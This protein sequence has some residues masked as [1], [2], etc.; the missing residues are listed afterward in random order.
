MMT[1]L[2]PSPRIAATGGTA[3]SRWRA[4]LT[5]PVAA[6]VVLVAFWF[7]LLASLD[8]KSLTSDEIVHATAGYT[9]WAFD[10]YRLNPENG[11]L[12][13]RVAGLALLTGDYQ[14]PPRDTDAWR[15]SNE[16]ELGDIWFHQMGHRVEDMLRRGRGA[17][18]LLSVI[19][20]ALVWAT[21]RRLFGPEGGML[22]L[23]V[24]VTSPIVLANGAL[25][26]SDAAC[27]LFFLAAT[28]ALWATLQR[29]TIPR[30]LGSGLLMGGLFVAKMSAVLVIPMA[31]LL[32]L[33]RALSGRA[34][35][36]LIGG[37]RELADLR[38][39]VA[40]LAAVGAVHAGLTVLVIWAFYGFRFQTFAP[41]AGAFERFQHPWRY[42]LERPDPLALLQEVNLTEPQKAR[43][44]AILSGFDWQHQAEE[45]AR[46]VAAQVLTPGQRAQLERRLA[47][48]PTRFAAQAFDFVRQHRL[49]PEAYV[50]G[51]AHAWRFAR[52]R[53]AFFNGEYGITGWKTFFPYTFA[54]KTP[55]ALFAILALAAAAVVVRWRRRAREEGTS[56]SQSLADG[57]YATLPLWVLLLVYWAAVIPGRL[58]IGHRHIMATY[59][60]LLV[61]AGAAGWWLKS[62]VHAPGMSRRAGRWISAA[63]VALLAALVAEMAYRFPHYISYFNG[64]VTPDKAYR[65]LVDSSLDWGQDLPGVRRYLAERQ[66]R[67]PVYFSY[68]GTASPRY[69]G[70]EA[71]FLYSPTVLDGPRTPVREL[72]TNERDL[73]RE[74]VDAQRAWPDCRPVL[75]TAD[76]NGGVTIFFLRQPVLPPLGGGTYLISATMLPAIWFGL[77]GPLGPW[78]PRFEARY[79]E[80]RALVAPLLVEDPQ[81]QGEA[82]ARRP[83]D[84]WHQI[85]GSFA[86]FRFARLTAFLRQR[87]PVANIGHSILVYELSPEE[88]RA[89]LDGPPPETGSDFPAQLA[90]RGE[91]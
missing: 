83:V 71:N 15:T 52:Q 12:P 21:A 53:S 61:L 37:R 51:Y 26:T 2:E 44:N 65:H 45:A 57:W 77:D 80:L 82:F 81:A 4:R 16:W 36:M 32:F 48:P 25:I 90:A 38:S 18:G 14:A 3:G 5:S 67:D 19:L 42:V 73:D 79:Q 39:R 9:Y 46:A 35:P 88:V 28:V 85:F 41:G 49:L 54:V 91:I 30:L 43:A 60:P 27:A 75:R 63:T 87:E 66:S 64:I 59:P 86:E 1:T 56:I 76:G 11:A 62:A 72:R 10:D 84:E 24:Y 68:F 8:E 31:S 22:S 13:Q 78:N 7:G 74:L 89:A 70:I 40:A 20:G 6:V 17:I 50:Y 34:W 55:L 69:Y 33:A 47:E 29:L 23:L 58:N